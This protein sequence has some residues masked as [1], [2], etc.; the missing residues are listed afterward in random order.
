[1]S[2]LLFSDTTVLINF[3]LI[4]RLD[5]LERIANGRG[6]WTATVASECKASSKYPGQ[7]SL[8]EVPAIL[9]EPIF[10][11]R[12]EL[13]QAMVLRDELAA[14]GDARHKHLGEAET[15]AVI[16]H[17]YRDSRF[18]TD[19]REAS[20]LASQ[21]GISAVTTW[22][23]FRL[24]VKVKFI[25]SDAAWGYVQTLRSQNRGAPP[26]VRTRSDLDTWLAT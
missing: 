5:L 19:D 24:A 17:R 15:L 6:A 14:P 1:M 2:P 16:E 8:R 13:Q 23:L 9:G 21:R 10:P 7:E 12:V 18:V 25:D 26:G 20:R 22:D 3:A 11:N 4:N